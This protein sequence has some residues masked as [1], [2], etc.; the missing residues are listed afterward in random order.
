MDIQVRLRNTVGKT[1]TASMACSGCQLQTVCFSSMGKDETPAENTI[2]HCMLALKNKQKLCFRSMPH[3]T[4]YALHAGTLKSTLSLGTAHG[5][6]D[7]HY[8]GELIAL[9]TLAPMPQTVV[10]EAIGDC[11]V[12]VIELNP[13]QL[14]KQALNSATASPA[15]PALLWQQMG[16]AISQY[17]QQ[18]VWRSH[19]PA[20][21]R[22]IRFL[23]QT[24]TR[25]Q[26]QIRL[27]MT[28]P[29]ANTSISY[30]IDL[31]MTRSDIANHLGLTL[32]TVCRLL[33]DLRQKKIIEIHARQLHIVQPSAFEKLSEQREVVSNK[34]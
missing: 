10:Y 11:A 32:E 18:Y 17:Q 19:L 2:T 29:S 26:A 27:G 8:A 1:P 14:D 13:S 25:Q 4:F 30:W 23:L 7:F 3:P 9:H 22:F 6:I 31:P 12:C 33:A 5:I 16:A 24:H 34:K 20:L 21:P 28:A 15:Q